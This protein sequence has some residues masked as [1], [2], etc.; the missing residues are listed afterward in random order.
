[1]SSTLF[2]LL[3]DSISRD[4]VAQPLVGSGVSLSRF[5]SSSVGRQATYRSLRALEV[6][7]VVPAGASEVS[8]LLNIGAKALAEAGRLG[9][10]TPMYFVLARK[11]A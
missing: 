5:R 7:R 11:P 2:S 10:F 3:K 6:L 8:R 4:T 1:M 9:I